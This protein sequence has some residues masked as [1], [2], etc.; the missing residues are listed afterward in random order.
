[1]SGKGELECGFGVLCFFVC[2]AL[3][4]LCC[5]ILRGQLCG[6][7]ICCIFKQSCARDASIYFPFTCQSG[8][9][10]PLIYNALEFG[11]FLCVVG[12]LLE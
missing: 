9:M 7:A 11:F 3:D 1:M 6:N 2:E 10:V 12:T 8:A 5:R 4:F